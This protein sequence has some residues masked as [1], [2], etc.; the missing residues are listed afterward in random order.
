M[1]VFKFL[2][3]YILNFYWILEFN[4]LKKTFYSKLY[5][6]GFRKSAFFW[7]EVHLYITN[8]S[9]TATPNDQSLFSPYLL[10]TLPG[11][12]VEMGLLYCEV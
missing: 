9:T 10:Q 7:R 12:L 5:L 1:I 4:D 11:Q 3:N 6:W 8:K 2:N